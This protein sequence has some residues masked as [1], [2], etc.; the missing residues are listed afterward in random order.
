METV[1]YTMALRI[2]KKYN[3]DWLGQKAR[4]KQEAILFEQGYRIIEEEEIKE[5]VAGNAC[6]L[7]LIF[8]PLIFIKTKMIKVTYE[9]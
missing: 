3:K 5:W 8:L 2:V 6:C 7:A 9:R 1:S 4:K